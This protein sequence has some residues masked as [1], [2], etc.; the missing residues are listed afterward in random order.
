[1][2]CR[3]CKGTELNRVLSLGNIV[4]STFVEEQPI[5]VKETP[6]NLTQCMRCG[7]VQLEN[8]YDLDKMYKEQYWYRSS[9]NNSMLRDLKDVVLGIEKR[10]VFEDGDVVIDIGCN[11]GALFDFYSNKTLYKIGYDPAPNLS[12]S[13]SRHC[14]LFVNDYFPSVST[15][16]K[17][18]VITSIAM[19]YDLP[20]PKLFCKEIKRNLA[21]NGLWVIQFTDLLSMFRANAFDNICHEHLEYYSLTVLENLLWEMGFTIFDLE[22]NKVNGGSLRVYVCHTGQREAF[23]LVKHARYEEQDYFEMHTFEDFEETIGKENN[24]TLTFLRQCDAENKKVF[25]LGASTKGNTLLQVF[26]IDNTLIPL[27]AEVN[28]DK[29]GLR[30]IASNIEIISEETALKLKPDYLFV[31]IWHFID[32]IISKQWAIDYMNG[33]GK[34]VVPLPEFRIYGKDGLDIG[35][36]TTGSLIDELI[37]T[38]MKCWYAQEDIVNKSLTEKERVDA[39]YK[40]QMMNARRNQ[41]IRKIDELLGQSSVSQ[42]G[43]TYG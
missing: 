29:F 2:E 25:L 12:E 28:S 38:D 18:K 15:N 6:L 23:E 13:A 11:D 27:A 24:K 4:P 36:K 1:M 32:N 8:T 22:Y 9:L 43:K 26:G 20:D 42:L 19:F 16:V 17:A 33:G 31:P 40:A 39:A 14:D 41:L 3:I 7:L 30:T 10:T 5:G 34:F 35:Q 21:N 37:T